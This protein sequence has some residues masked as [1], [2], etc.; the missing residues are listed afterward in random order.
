[1]ATRARDAALRRGHG[2]DP[3]DFPGRF[4]V[5]R[6]QAQADG[7]LDLVVRLADAGEHDFVGREPGAKGDFDFAAGVGI[8]VRAEAA[9]SAGRRR[10]WRWP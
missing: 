3:L 7:A 10:A 5:D 4:G 8:R 6:V 2:L 9:A 1:M